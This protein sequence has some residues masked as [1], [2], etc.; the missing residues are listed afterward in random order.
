MTDTLSMTKP[1]EK[2]RIYSD[3]PSLYISFLAINQVGWMEGKGVRGE[4]GRGEVCLVI[5]KKTSWNF[6]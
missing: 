6:Y 5:A 3:G 1:E 4:G 2:E